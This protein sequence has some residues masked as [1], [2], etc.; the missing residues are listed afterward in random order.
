VRSSTIA[1]GPEAGKPVEVAAFRPEHAERFRSLNRAWLQADGLLEPP[2]E[3]QLADP[4]THIIARGG[5]I[6]VALRDG[7]VV[8]T[9]ALLPHGAGE[10]EI[11]KLAVAPA[12]RGQGLGRRLVEWCLARAR[13]QGAHRVVLISSSRLQSALRLYESLGFQYRP[14]PATEYATADIYMELDLTASAPSR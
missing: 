13:E 9:C 14:M 3:L 5:Q 12:A 11:V 2:D 1:T 6:A 8:G 7:E 4:Q 10:L